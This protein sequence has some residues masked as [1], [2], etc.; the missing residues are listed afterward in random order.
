MPHPKGWSPARIAAL[1]R[2]EEKV[3]DK[4]GVNKYAVCRASVGRT[5]AMRK[6]AKKGR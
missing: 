3:G 2:C 4:P 1:K 5:K 6:L